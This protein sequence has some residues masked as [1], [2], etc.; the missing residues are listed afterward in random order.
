M[1]KI[2]N[3]DVILKFSRNI[4]GSSPLDVRIFLGH[5]LETA[6]KAISQY[7]K[8]EKAPEGS[9][10]FLAAENIKDENL[11]SELEAFRNVA[12]LYLGEDVPDDVWEDACQNKLSK[13]TRLFVL[14]NET[15]GRTVFLR[16][17]DGYPF[18]P[19]Y[20][21]KGMLKNQMKIRCERER[22]GRS[23]KVRGVFGETEAYSAKL[24]NRHIFIHQYGGKSEKNDLLNA[25][26]YYDSPTGSKRNKGKMN[27]NGTP[28]TFSRPLRAVTAQGERNSLIESEFIEV[29]GLYSRKTNPVYIRFRVKSFIE[30]F[31]LK[32]L[33]SLLAGGEDYGFGQ[34]RNAGWGSFTVEKVKQSVEA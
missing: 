34:W 1:A 13:N 9:T 24:M 33:K 21:V 15:K 3:F 23:E 17:E 12:K 32:M 29:A 18:M 7:A 30:E 6:R 5:Q 10:N 8:K 2:R 4:L 27:P 11:R 16:D 19:L 26:F 14:L 25:F 31:D 20:V 22:S 28:A